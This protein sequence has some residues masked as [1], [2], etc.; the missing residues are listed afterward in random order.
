MGG[1]IAILLALIIVVVA[2]VIG[3]VLYFTGAA[4]TFR[5]HE[6]GED[7]TEHRPTNKE[8]TSPELEHT[9]FG[10][11]SEDSVER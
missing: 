8:V 7:G 6:P 9:N 4:L 2:I 1:G 5:K 10:S 3:A 11:R